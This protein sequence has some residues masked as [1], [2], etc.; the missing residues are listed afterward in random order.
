ME[1]MG[2][3]PDIATLSLMTDILLKKERA[4]EVV[5]FVQ[6]MAVSF[7]SSSPPPSSPSYDPRNAGACYNTMMEL[8]GKEGNV[9]GVMRL[10]HQMASE[11]ALMVFFFI[12]IDISFLPLPMNSFSLFFHLLILSH[13]G[14]RQNPKIRL[15]FLHHLQLP[16]QIHLH[17]PHRPPLP[18][19]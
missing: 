2:V 1:E 18:P 10:L 8:Y 3:S 17:C 14:K 19:H 12:I 6:K 16:P 7:E 11:S 4:D 13:P 15:P 9:E 5:E